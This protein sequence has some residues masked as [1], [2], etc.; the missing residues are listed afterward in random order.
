MQQPPSGHCC[1]WSGGIEQP[2][3]GCGQTVAPWLS[4]AAVPVSDRCRLVPLHL[5]WLDARHDR[6]EES[7]DLLLGNMITS[8][9]E[10]TRAVGMLSARAG[11]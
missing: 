11:Q 5:E 7:R 8:V 6:C 3:T 9:S 1:G 2:R 4:A 10:V